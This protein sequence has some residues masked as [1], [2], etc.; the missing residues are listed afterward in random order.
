M[1]EKQNLGFLPSDGE[2]LF[3]YTLRIRDIMQQIRH[4]A[5]TAHEKWYTHYSVGSCFICELMDMCDYMQATLQDIVN[6][7]KKG[8]W[9][10]FRPTESHD[11]L[12][13]SFQ[14]H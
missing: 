5:A 7:D 8:H 9:K 13:F 2:T 6:Y 12:T 14:R 10:C 3:A 4:G 11:A 1:N